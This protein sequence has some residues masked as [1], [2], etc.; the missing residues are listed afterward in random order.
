MKTIKAYIADKQMTFTLHP[1]FARLQQNAPLREVFPFIST[2]TF[3][4]VSADLDELL[5]APATDHLAQEHVAVRVE[6]NRV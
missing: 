1:L 5:N 2:L 4:L 3:P 6:D